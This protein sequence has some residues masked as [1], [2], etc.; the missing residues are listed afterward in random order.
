MSVSG[1]G[2]TASQLMPLDWSI[3]PEELK[4]TKGGVPQTSFLTALTGAAKPRDAASASDI[5]AGPAQG[6]NSG[7]TSTQKLEKSAEE[8]FLDFSK[9]SEVDKL[10]MKELKDKDLSE[11]KLN[12][13]DAQQRE[14]LEEGIR[15][16]VEE[17]VRQ[18]TG[19]SI[20]GIA[21]ITV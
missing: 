19:K 13:M 21:D 20:G 10:R 3:S 1:L 9:L 18:Q 2:S 5:F 12:E 4:K 8:K 16:K 11:E 15:A 6:D 14:A 17:T 7:N